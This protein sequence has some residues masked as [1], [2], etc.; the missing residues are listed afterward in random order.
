MFAWIKRSKEARLALAVCA[1]LVMARLAWAVLLILTGF[2]R[3]W[4]YAPSRDTIEMVSIY[5]GFVL[6]VS[7]SVCLWRSRRSKAA[8]S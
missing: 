5:G 6:I 7:L 4:T 8:T 1:G 3:S 2:V